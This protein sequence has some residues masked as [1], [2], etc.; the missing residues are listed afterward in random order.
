MAAVFGWFLGLF[1][2]QDY[3]KYRCKSGKTKY[4]VKG[5]KRK[6]K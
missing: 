1:G 5:K 4:A 3:T 2:T 6:R